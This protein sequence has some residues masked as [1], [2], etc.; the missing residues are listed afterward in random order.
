MAPTVSITSPVADADPNTPGVQVVEGSTIPIEVAVT[1]D[2]QVRNVELLVNGQV[3]ANDVSLPFDFVAIAPALASGVTTRSRSRSG[4][5]TPAATAPCRTSLTYSL[6]KDTVPPTR[7]RHHADRRPEASSTPRRS[8]SGSASRSTRPCSNLPRASR[9]RTSAPT[10]RRPPATSRPARLAPVTRPGPR[11]LDLSRERPRHRQLPAD[12]R[13]VGH[14]RPRRQPPGRA[15]HAR[16]SRSAPASNIQPLAGFAAIHRAPGG[17]RRPGDRL[18]GPLA[19]ARTPDSPSPRST[20]AATPAPSI[21][22]PSRF[23]ATTQTAYFV[24]PTDADTGNITISGTADRE[25][26]RVPQLERHPGQREPLTADGLQRPPAGQRACTSTWPTTATRRA[27]SRRAPASRSS[28]ARTSSAS[29]SPARS[30]ARPARSPSRSGRPIPKTFTN[31]AGNAAFATDHRRS[32]SRPATTAARSSSTRPAAQRRMLLDN[33]TLTKQADQRGPAE[34]QLRHD[35]PRRPAAAPDRAAPRRASPIRRRLPV[36]RRPTSTC[37][38]SGFAEGGSRSIR[39]RRPW[40]TPT[41]ASAIDVYSSGTQPERQL[42]RAS[43][44]APSSARSA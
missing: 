8:T 21:V 42:R 43:R 17:E 29:S 4:P 20:T 22:A 11:A 12:D 41:P 44:P 23:D 39:R 18:P 2:V 3:V 40:S 34:R 1:D 5:P 38:G 30:R 33:V 35:V 37:T 14:R 36:P 6:V 32:P 24:V 13:P 9:S 28:R 10:A 15:V 27:S 19:G 31:I 16:R 7:R 26:H 25:L